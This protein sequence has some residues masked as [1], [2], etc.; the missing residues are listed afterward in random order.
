MSITWDEW[1]GVDSKI[2]YLIGV[3][4]DGEIMWTRRP[5]AIGLAWRVADELR[6]KYHIDTLLGVSELGKNGNTHIAIRERFRPRKAVA[7]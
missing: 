3:D 6:D 4:L 5:R 2:E 1:E 7:K